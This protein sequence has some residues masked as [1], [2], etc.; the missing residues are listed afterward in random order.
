MR[1][2]RT[3]RS[4]RGPASRGSADCGAETGARARRLP[5]PAPSACPDARTAPLHRVHGQRADG[6][7]AAPVEL[8]GYGCGTVD[9][10]VVRTPESRASSALCRQTELLSS[11]GP[12]PQRKGKL[13]REDNRAGLPSGRRLRACFPP[14]HGIRARARQRQRHGDAQ[15]LSGNS[16]PPV[17]E[18]VLE[19]TNTIAPSMSI[20]N[21]SPAMST[22][23]PGE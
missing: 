6:V 19:G 23:I 22:A 10:G 3:A 4:G 7:D 14:A 11:A 17:P 18:S 13:R 2:H 15:Q 1:V 21:R 20:A 16:Q 12:A 5:A 9:R 8:V